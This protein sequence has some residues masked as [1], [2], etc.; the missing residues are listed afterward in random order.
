MSVL[1]RNWLTDHTPRYAAPHCTQHHD[2]RHRCCC[3]VRCA[4]SRGQARVSWVL[5][6][7][8][9]RDD[10]GSSR[11]A[12]ERRASWDLRAAR[13]GDPIALF[14]HYHRLPPTAS[15][16]LEWLSRS[17]SAGFAKAQS[18]LG[19]LLLEG[20]PSV[21]RNTTAAVGCGR[22][23]PLSAQGFGASLEAGRTG[24]SSI[25]HSRTNPPQVEQRATGTHAQEGAFT[26]VVGPGQAAQL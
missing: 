6:Y 9:G 8:D 23:R 2:R 1:E 25:S 10:G 24:G 20:S 22:S 4:R 12:P 17:A 13:D 26:S 18:D 21:G 16:R 14:L 3:V 7:S 11:C 5:W 19:R 15:G